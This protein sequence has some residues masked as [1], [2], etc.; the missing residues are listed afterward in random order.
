MT[1]SGT[2]P[3]QI[4][5]HMDDQSHR[6]S[7]LCDDVLARIIEVVDDSQLVVQQVVGATI[8]VLVGVDRFSVYLD[9]HPPIIL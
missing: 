5:V 7:L 8:Q 3:F 6:I 4:P 9:I 2:A 1:T